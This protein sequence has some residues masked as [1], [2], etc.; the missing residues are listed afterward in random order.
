[1]EFRVHLQG[2]C[3]GW[4]GWLNVADKCGGAWP[5]RVRMYSV[6]DIRFLVPRDSIL[7]SKTAANSQLS[8]S[9]ITWP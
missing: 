1:M 2:S 4:W 7:F 3:C 9:S 6:G 5:L 8:S